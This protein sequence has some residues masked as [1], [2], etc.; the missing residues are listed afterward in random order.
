MILNTVHSQKDFNQDIVK[1][2]KMLASLD[3]DVPQ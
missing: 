2:I 1:E 3:P